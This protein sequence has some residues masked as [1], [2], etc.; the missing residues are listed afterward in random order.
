MIKQLREY[1]I[2]GIKRIKE[3]KNFGLFWQQRL[4]KTIVSIKAVEDF[5]K[6]I[7]A[8]PNNT[9]HHWEKEIKENTNKSVLIL[10]KIIAKRNLDYK[11]FND[12][13][14][15]W[16]IC[17]YDTISH[18]FWKSRELIKNFDYIV[19][20]EAHFLRNSKSR[21]TKGILK[22]REKS[23]YA[24]AISGTP[25]VNNSIDI[26]KIF[27]FL[28]PEEKYGYKYIFKKKYF[29]S[30]INKENSKQYWT[31]KKD[32]INEWEKMLSELCDIK[33][34]HDY[35]KWLPKNIYKSFLVDM[36]PD[37]RLHYKKMLLESKRLIG[38][39]KEKKESKTITQI[40]RLQ[41][42]C[43]DPKLLD[44]E[45]S[46]AKIKWLEEYLNETLQNDDEFIIVFT[47]FTSLYEKVKF[48]IDKEYKYG[49]LTGLQT[50]EEKQKTIKD[51]QDKKI[52]V[53]FANIKV[54][55]LGLTLD[56]ATIT[57][58]LDKSWSIV[59]NEQA[60]FRMVDTVEQENLKSKL[61]VSV[62]C[63]NSIDQRINDVLE[64][65][66][67]KTNIIYEIGKYIE[68]S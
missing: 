37:Q 10:S 20:D 57:I 5:N 9:V 36:G 12:N 66:K 32:M 49:F 14:Q 43:L 41:Q 42:L 2:D 26:L 38:E 59:D 28:F 51:F 58:F 39:T 65:K 45:S 18:D 34:V 23:K 40:I 22:L 6:V 50:S 8:V 68:E 56:S 31:L 17:S 60:S 53:L 11:K 47:N 63:N 55:G 67:N 27:K 7:F 21:R 54:A 13:E 62:I 29:E 25:A 3:K 48:N 19:L 15:C 1:Q 64:N 4:G 16:L 44:I 46:S 33:K 61:I 30:S 35:L 52:R 24:L